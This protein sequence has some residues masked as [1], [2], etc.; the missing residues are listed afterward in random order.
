VHKSSKYLFL[1]RRP[2]IV[3]F[4]HCRHDSVLDRTNHEYRVVI[5]LMSELVRSK[6]IS[7]NG[8]KNNLII[9]RYV[10]SIFRAGSA[11]TVNVKLSLCL[12]KHHACR[13]TG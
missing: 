2:S 10:M 6:V 7:L 3:V 4:F 8:S 11:K 9:F 13:R 1:L 5:L 12:I